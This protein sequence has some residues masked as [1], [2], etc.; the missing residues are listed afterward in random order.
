M[1]EKELNVIVK[2]KAGSHLYGT[3]SDQSDSDY[4]GIYLPESSDIILKKDKDV[5]N[6]NTN[7]SSEKN[8]KKDV[9]V[10]YYSLYK[11]LQLCKK[12]ETVAIDMLHTPDNMLEK[13]SEAWEFIRK[14][15]SKFYTTSISAFLGYCKSQAIKY[16]EKGNRLAA[17]ENAYEV[18]KEINEIYGH[19]SKNLLSDVWH[20][21]YI[22]GEYCYFSNDEYGHWYNVLDKKFLNSTT[23]TYVM[24][25]LYSIKTSYGKR[26]INAKENKG[27]DWKAISHAFRYGYELKELF[28]TGDIVFPLRDADFIK[29]LKYGKCDYIND[30]VGERLEILVSDVKKLVAENKFNFPEE[31]DFSFWERFL[32]WTH[33]YNNQ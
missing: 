8:T 3:N 9:D 31:V 5:I 22:N 29:S 25:Q 28:E 13:T 24:N 11:F 27:V 21:L 23:S 2:M 12:G 6:F 15:R 33:S 1:E 26:V 19:E 18:L 20:Y 10:E 14:N 32:L 4:K 30:N 16:G 7:N 17:V